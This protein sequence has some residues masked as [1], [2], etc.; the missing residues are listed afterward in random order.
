MSASPTLPSLPS[1]HPYSILTVQSY[2]HPAS[3]GHEPFFSP[4]ST[5]HFLKLS[6]LNLCMRCD[7][8]CSISQL[9]AHGR[10]P[11]TLPRGPFLARS[12]DV[13]S[14]FASTAST[15]AAVL[16]I[17]RDPITETQP[18]DKA[19][20]RERERQAA[21]WFWSTTGIRGAR[22]SRASCLPRPARYGL[23]SGSTNPIGVKISSLG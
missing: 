5:R 16:S 21:G 10:S 7:A 22:V 17:E 15:T 19:H 13:T 2:H 8:G 18:R 23:E 14:V 12:F 9:P 3:P 4:N 11:T 1:T 6:A 20:A